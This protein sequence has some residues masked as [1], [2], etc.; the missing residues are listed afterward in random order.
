MIQ[1]LILHID[2]LQ[3]R[4]YTLNRIGSMPLALLSQRF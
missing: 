4:G 1:H 3:L 2:S